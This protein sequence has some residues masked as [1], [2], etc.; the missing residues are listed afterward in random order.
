MCLERLR[1]C[2]YKVFQKKQSYKQIDESHPDSAAGPAGVDAGEWDNWDEVE[3][4][5]AVHTTVPT[6]RQEQVRGQ[7]GDGSTTTN[8]AAAHESSGV[9]SNVSAVRKDVRRAK[10][11]WVVSKPRSSGAR[12]TL[13]AANTTSVNRSNPFEDMGM[14]AQ[15]SRQKKLTSTI[16]S[17]TSALLSSEVGRGSR[18]MSSADDSGSLAANGWN[19]GD[20]L[21]LG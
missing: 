3:A 9:S 21:D 16:R 20:D 19:D 17:S 1:N 18:F 5:A 10:A 4:G 12:S 2:L 15:V 11:G 13:R 6:Q 14:V 7:P 8:F